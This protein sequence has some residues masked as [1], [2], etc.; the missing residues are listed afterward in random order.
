MKAFNGDTYMK[1]EFEKL[2]KEY[3]IKTIIETGTYKGDTTLVL[4][5]MV[6]NVITVELSDTYFNENK[7]RFSGIKNIHAVE[8]N[9]VDLLKSINPTN[10]LVFLDAHWNDYCPLL[11]ELKAI[12]NWTEKPVI[13]I[14]DFKVPDHPELGFDSYNGQD[15]DFGF[16]AVELLSIYGFNFSH[17]SNT[18]A[19]GSK[20]GVIYIEPKSY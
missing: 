15:Y 2:I 12:S 19:S 8:G 6:E 4:A 16:I 3:G 18:E 17:Y 5:D 1:L 11:D 20:R 10:A 14:H 7:E 13:V 9:S